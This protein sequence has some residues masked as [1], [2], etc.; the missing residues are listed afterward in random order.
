MT[1][2]LMSGISPSISKLVLHFLFRLRNCHFSSLFLSGSPINQHNSISII[3]LIRTVIFYLSL[4]VSSNLI[5]STLRII[6]NF[7]TSK[8]NSW[9]SLIEVWVFSNF[10]RIYAIFS[11]LD[12]PPSHSFSIVCN[13]LT[14]S[15]LTARIL[16]ISLLPVHLQ[17]ADPISLILLLFLNYFQNHFLSKYSRKTN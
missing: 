10:F 11:S 3:S 2:R 16:M 4:L 15:D 5:F 14:V 17:L 8:E 9:I 13:W 12:P 1:S 7:R 6:W